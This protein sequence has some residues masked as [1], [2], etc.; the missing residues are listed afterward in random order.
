[1]EQLLIFLI[2]ATGYG[3]IEIIWRGYTHWTMLIT[4]GVCFL[5]LYNVFNILE[6]SPSFIKAIVGSL[7]ITLIEF[8]AG[9]IINVKFG[10]GVW[11]YSNLPFNVYGQICLPYTFLWFSL[12]F[13][14]IYLCNW[15]K[16]F[17]LIKKLT[18]R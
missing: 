14:L 1:M 2:G 6:D 18:S 3:I 17:E 7:T 13:P 15:L 10:L 5:F 12:C 4:G 8:I 11:D 16:S 9:M